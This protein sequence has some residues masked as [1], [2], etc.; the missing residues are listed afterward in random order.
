MTVLP[1]LKELEFEERKHTYL[2][3][4]IEIPSVTTL[5]EPLSSKVYGPVDP[6]VLANAASKGT[7]VHNAIENYLE[8]EVTDISD[9]HKG[10]FDAFLAWLDACRPVIVG[11]E[12]RVYHKQLRY[13]GTSDLICEINGQNVLVDYKTSYQVNM[14]LYMVQLEGYARAWES[15]GVRIDDRIILHLKKDG[16]YAV[17]HSPKNAE[18]YSVLSALLTIRNYQTKF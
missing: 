12:A 13:A 5:M 1:E 15:H 6:V 3:N 8:F 16:K 7:A 18:C 11:T 17:Y 4:G 9:E 14:M 10:Y 2:L